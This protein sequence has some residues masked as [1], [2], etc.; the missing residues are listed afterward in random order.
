MTT[1]KLIAIVLAVTGCAGASVQPAPDDST[2]EPVE[3]GRRYISIGV[4]AIETARQIALEA[5]TTIDVLESKDGVAI[6][7]FEHRRSRSCRKRCTTSIT[8]AADSRCTTRWMTRS[9]HCARSR[10]KARHARRQLHARRWRDRE[11]GAA[12]SRP[13][14]YPRDDQRAVGDAEPL[15]HVGDRRRG[16]DVAARSLARLHDAHRCHRRAG[17]SRLRAEVGDPDDP[18]HDAR[19]RGRRPRRSPRLDR[20]RW[21]RARSRPA[22]TTTHRGIATLTEVARVLLAK[23]YRPARTIKLIAYAAEEVGLRGSQGI[24]R[25]HADA[26]RRRRRRACSST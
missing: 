21:Q 17:R 1:R 25:D 12:R 24:V 20:V 14:A 4:D 16:V 3:T 13:V 6:I 8:A 7:G 15:L 23:D 2:P 19:E 9:S 18:G 5:G 11:R 26:R 22:P 10:T